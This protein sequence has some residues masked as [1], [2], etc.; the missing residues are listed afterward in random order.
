M[1]AG[2][3]VS[4]SGKLQGPEVEKSGL[5]R[6]A[7]QEAGRGQAGPSQAR[8]RPGRGGS[9]ELGLAWRRPGLAGPRPGQA[10]PACQ[11]QARQA[12]LDLGTAPHSEFFYHP[13]GRVLFER[14]CKNKHFVRK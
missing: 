3:L 14:E 10:G 12:G 5:G 2:L 9:T 7:G 11:G 1:K 8:A 6:R 4:L 13:S